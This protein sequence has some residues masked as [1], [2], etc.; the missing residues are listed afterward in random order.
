MH[1]I[2]LTLIL[3]DFSQFAQG[4]RKSV[5]SLLTQVNPKQLIL[6]PATHSKFKLQD[7]MSNGSGTEHYKSKPTSFLL[8][9]NL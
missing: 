9:T 5:I 3:K 1:T 4:N 8:L 7:F 6:H 2:R